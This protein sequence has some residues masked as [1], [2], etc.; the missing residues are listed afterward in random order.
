ME[1]TKEPLCEN[2]IRD[3]VGPY[4]YGGKQ[5]VTEHCPTLKAKLQLRKQNKE[6]NQKITWP[7]QTSWT[8]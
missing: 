6:R 5:A 3:L 7:N 1:I 2:D 8:L 4:K